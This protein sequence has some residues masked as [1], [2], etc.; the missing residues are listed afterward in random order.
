MRAFE[1]ELWDM[2]I[3]NKITKSFDIFV[4]IFYD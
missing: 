4:K 3:G 2:N 1:D